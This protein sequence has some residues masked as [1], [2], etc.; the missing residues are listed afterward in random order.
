MTLARA[1]AAIRIPFSGSMI[2]LCRHASKITS[3]TP[4]EFELSEDQ[5]AIVNA[6]GQ[7]TADFDDD[8]WLARDRDGAF[9]DAFHRAMAE[10]GWLGI[11]MP[12]EAGGA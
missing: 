12:E 11:A 10:G 7:I 4:M 5:T 1:R 6:V 3:G 8:Y 9:P 2:Y